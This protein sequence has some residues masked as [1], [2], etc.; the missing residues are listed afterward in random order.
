MRTLSLALVVGLLA[1]APPAARDTEVEPP[2]DTGSQCTSSKN[3]VDQ[4]VCPRLRNAGCASAPLASSAE[5]CR[6]LHVDLIGSAPTPAQVQSTCAGKDASAIA[7]A[8][9]A[10]P[11]YVRQSQEL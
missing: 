7:T 1:C 6:R 11:E 5:L 2:R 8:L 10:T 3:L 9:M 4:A